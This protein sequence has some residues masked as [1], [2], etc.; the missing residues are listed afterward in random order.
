MKIHVEGLQITPVSQGIL[1]IHQKRPPFYFSCCD[2]LLILPNKENNRNAIILDANI[3]PI[4]VR[5]LVKQVES[6]KNYVCSHGHMD[7]IAHV[8]AWE[9]LG[10]K[11]WAPHPENSC[12]TDLKHFYESFGF[13]DKLDFSVIRQFGKIN[14]YEKCKKVNTF[15]PG[16]VLDFDGYK[17]ET[18]P[19][20]GHSKS[21]VGFFLPEEKIL[22]VSC[23]GFDMKN[24]GK[25]GFGP[26]YGFKECSISQYLLD[27]DRCEKIFLQN[28]RYLTS[29]HSYIVNHPDLTPF[30]Y[31]R[32][33]IGENHAKI[34][35]AL[36][37]INPKINTGEELIGELLKQDIFFPKRKMKDFLLEIYTLWE[38]WMIKKHLEWRRDRQ[39]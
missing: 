19:L 29:S 36:K 8:H 14:G 39:K 7:H 10:T 25:E 3:E 5:A 38:E 31:M 9:E 12:L 27:I 17:I 26:W 18:I 32:K 20:K 34:E 16:D 33:K 35:H 6:I 30:K 24:P 13:N 23:L 11:I 37:N 28:A 22:H 2:G 1:L 15:E 21:H 4:H